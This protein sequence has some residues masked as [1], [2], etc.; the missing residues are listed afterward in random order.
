MAIWTVDRVLRLVRLV[1]CNLHVS[2]GSASIQRTRSWATYDESSNVVRLRV[3]PAS[4]F[5]PTPGP[6]YFLYQPFRLTGWESHPFTLGAWSYGPEAPPGF[7]TTKM[8]PVD[9]AHVPLLSDVSSGSDPVET[10]QPAAE[11]PALQLTFWIRPYDGWTRYLRDQCLRS[12]DRTTKATILLEGPYGD[13]FP[14]WHYES[15]L[16][17]VGGTGIAAAVPYIQE[18]LR[19]SAIGKTRIRDIHLVWTS[20][21]VSFMTNVA[22]Q[23]LRQALA[24][25]DVRASFHAT[26]GSDPAGKDMLFDLDVER[27]TGR[28]DLS[29]LV[30]SHVHEARLSDYSAAILM[31]GPRAMADET[32]TAVYGAMR[33]GYEV[34]YVEDSFHW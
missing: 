30:I 20:R 32:R 23:E 11:P 8:S 9:V 19:R 25:E 1:Y 34:K 21:Q 28:P 6:Y 13:S 14:L 10:P 29:S 16:F 22:T 18:H 12:P 17:V 7:P 31:C 15:I 26:A 2:V 4:L 3:T 33:Q 24:R 5:Q 27:E